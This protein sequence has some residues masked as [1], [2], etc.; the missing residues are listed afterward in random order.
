MSLRSTVRVDS[1]LVN[2]PLC[3]T[4]QRWRES[5]TV[6]LEVI[7]VTECTVYLYQGRRATFACLAAVPCHGKK[8]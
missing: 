3:E 4:D 8:P 7:C 1:D 2:L 6:V 5:F